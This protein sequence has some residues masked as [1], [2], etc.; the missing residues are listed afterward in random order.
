MTKHHQHVRQQA[1]RAVGNMGKLI[2]ER[3]RMLL[4]PVES[5]TGSKQ[6]VDD[7]RRRPLKFDGSA[8]VRLRAL[9]GWKADGGKS[10]F[11]TDCWAKYPPFQTVDDSAG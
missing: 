9:N 6:R 7:R 4:D 10:R 8:R 1:K 11:P 2:P 5:K 3:L